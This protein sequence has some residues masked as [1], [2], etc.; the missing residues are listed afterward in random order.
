MTSSTRFPF[1][2]A[3]KLDSRTG[4]TIKVTQL[5]PS[6]RP[7]LVLVGGEPCSARY[8]SERHG[9]CRFSRSIEDDGSVASGTSP[10]SSASGTSLAG[11]GSCC[12]CR[13]LGVMLRLRYAMDGDYRIHRKL[14]SRGGMRGGGRGR[15]LGDGTMWSSLMAQLVLTASHLKDLESRLQEVDPS[16]S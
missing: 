10:N 16:Q 7:A 12:V 2:A 6:M 11:T 1:F 14:S 8:C 13:L 9:R 15:H 4:S 5:H 3:F